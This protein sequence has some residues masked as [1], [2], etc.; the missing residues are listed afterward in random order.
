MDDYGWTYGEQQAV[1]EWFRE[2]EAIN[3]QENE[4]YF[5]STPSEAATLKRYLTT[6]WSAHYAAVA[7]IAVKDTRPLCEIYGEPNSYGRDGILV[8][9]LNGCIQNLP[10]THG[11][12]SE[13]VEAIKALKDDELGL[14]GPQMQD[15]AVWGDKIRLEQFWTIVCDCSRGQSPCVSLLSPLAYS[16]IS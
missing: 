16:S 6:A 2:Q 1:D 7:L 14:T 5:L 4:E 15:L 3:D 11:R 10:Q 13:L 9:M 12:I 8:W